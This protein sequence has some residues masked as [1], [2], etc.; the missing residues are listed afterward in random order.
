VVS[1]CGTNGI[2]RLIGRPAGMSVEAA[3]TCGKDQTQL[4]KLAAVVRGVG[5]KNQAAAE[6]LAVS[7][8]ECIHLFRRALFFSA[9]RPGV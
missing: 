9:A 3:G 4:G 5:G 1:A 2:L 6:E 7:P 8:A